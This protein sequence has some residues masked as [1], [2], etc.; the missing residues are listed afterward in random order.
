MILS[1]RKENM[2]ASIVDKRQI[3]YLGDLVRGA[4]ISIT[5]LRKTNKTA[6]PPFARGVSELQVICTRSIIFRMETMTAII[7]RMIFSPN[8]LTNF[9]ITFAEKV[10]KSNEKMVQGS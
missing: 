8:T 10:I 4:H 9:P 1:K 2:L 6:G 5:N 3:Q 7:T